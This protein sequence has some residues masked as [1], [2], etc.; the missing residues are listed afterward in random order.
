MEDKELL[1]RTG[2]I[3]LV[4]VLI[5][6]I[7]IAQ[8]ANLQVLQQTYFI[9]KADAQRFRSLPIIA[10]RGEVFDRNGEV[11]VS[12]RP[13]Y[14]VSVH[15]PYYEDEGL[16]QKLSEILAIPLDEIRKKV[17]DK[18]QK[19][20]RL[21]DP[22]RLKTDLSPE[23]HTILVERQA[24][25]PGVTVEVQPIR[26]YRLKD[27]AAQVIG[28][29]GEISLDQLQQDRWKQEDYKPGDIIGKTGLEYY[30]EEYL[31]GL[32]GSQQVEVDYRFRPTFRNLGQID[33]E[34]GDNLI[35]TLD[36]R[37]QKVAEMAMDQTLERIRTYKGSSGPY[38]NARTGAAVVIDVRTGEVLAMVNRPGYDL[39]LFAVGISPDDYKRMAQ[40]PLKP[41][42]NRAI[43]GT[44]APGS[45][46]KMVG[47]T[48]TLEYQVITPEGTV[49]CNGF[50]D[51][52][53]IGK[54]CWNWRDGGHG[55]V[56]MRRALKVSCDIYFYEMGYRLGNDRLTEYAIAYGFGQQTGVDLAGEA[57]GTIPTREWL[58][59]ERAR[60]K[61]PKYKL[62]GGEVLNVV[63]G[64]GVV[65]ATPVQLATYTSAVANGGTLY[66]P[67]L[68]KRIVSPEGEV[69]KEFAPEV[70]GTVAVTPENL[71]VVREGMLEVTR[72][73]GTSAWTFYDFPIPVAAKT[74]TAQR[75]GQEYDNGLYVAYA[76]YDNP[77]IAIAIV[78]EQGGSGSLASPIAKAVFAEYFGILLRDGDPAKIIDPNAPP[79]FN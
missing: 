62:P 30:Y 2:Q 53:V 13:A 6:L 36:A 43:S 14:T 44:Y 77:E 79:G 10:P 31:R 69:V 58:E 33:P 21:F 76:P 9:N 41:F 35:L 65:T 61:D 4:L 56:D 73:G 7:L 74:G 34:P 15:Y 17:R 16:Q 8:L 46:F 42:H 78:V 52:L 12:N 48:A 1:R 70:R 22:I 24:E 45:T 28:Y 37:L 47:A 64:Q 67:H 54:K 3:T 60:R 66:R 40:D 23:V 49:F 55:S 20:R 68:V 26:E 59:K 18:T 32:D 39:N 19:E 11:I 50:Y 51:K 63:I 38:P 71:K 72:P 5:F 29:V 57:S 27:E 75:T 25:L